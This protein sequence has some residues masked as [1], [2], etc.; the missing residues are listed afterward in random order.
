MKRFKDARKEFERSS[1]TL[2]AALGRN[3]QAP[4]GKTHEV[5]EASQA[6]IQAR[7]AFR[8]GTLDYVLQ[9]PH[10]LDVKMFHLKL[11]THSSS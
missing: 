3:A 8:S 5:E 1:E 2:E 4:R 11:R 9:V 6:L 10:F 7:K